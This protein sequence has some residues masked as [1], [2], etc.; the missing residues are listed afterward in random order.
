MKGFY[1]SKPIDQDD[2]AT[3]LKK[4]LASTKND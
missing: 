1:F 2:F 3:L 4:H